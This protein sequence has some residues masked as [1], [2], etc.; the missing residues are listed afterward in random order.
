MSGDGGE[1]GRHTAE[2]R[3]ELYFLIARFLESGPCQQAAQ[4]LIREVV[5]KELLPKRTDWTGKEHPR[6]Y[7]NLISALASSASGHVSKFIAQWVMHTVT[8]LVLVFEDKVE[9]DP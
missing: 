4:V 1:S 3:A 5:E 8:S 7:E 6:S 2:L 9:I